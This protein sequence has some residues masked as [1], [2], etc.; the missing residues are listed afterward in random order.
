MFFRIRILILFYVLF[1]FP[2]KCNYF[3]M[4]II[5]LR[6]VCFC[7]FVLCCV[8]LCVFIFGSKSCLNYFYCDAGGIQIVGWTTGSSAGNMRRIIRWH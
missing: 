1:C 3:Y 5:F 8:V 6:V 2:F 7:C 4:R